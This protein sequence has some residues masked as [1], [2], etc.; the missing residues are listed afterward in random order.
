VTG[1]IN[2]DEVP[3]VV[4]AVHGGEVLLPCVVHGEPPPVVS[5]RFGSRRITSGQYTG[6]AAPYRDKF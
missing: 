4:P 3:G 1:D 6:I 2:F 5:W